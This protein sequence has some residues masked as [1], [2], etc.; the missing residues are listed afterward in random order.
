MYGVGVV[1]PSTYN[2]QVLERDVICREGDSP[3]IGLRDIN[4]SGR[5]W[6]SS[7][8]ERYRYADMLDKPGCSQLDEVP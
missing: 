1:Y 7:Q 5:V 6:V 3:T 2:G 8:C 4:N